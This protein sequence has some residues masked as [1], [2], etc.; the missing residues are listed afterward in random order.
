MRIAPELVF[1]FDEKQR[2]RAMNVIKMHWLPKFRSGRRMWA[3]GVL[4]ARVFSVD[5]PLKRH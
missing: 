3:V 4:Q 1:S 5:T 2:L